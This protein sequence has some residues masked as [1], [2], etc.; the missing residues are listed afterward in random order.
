MRKLTDVKKFKK[1]NIF[2]IISQ[3]LKKLNFVRLNCILNTNKKGKKSRKNKENR[4]SDTMTQYQSSH[5]Q[6]YN[7]INQRGPRR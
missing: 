4:V 1:N 7:V 5:K 6:D 3:T 2:L